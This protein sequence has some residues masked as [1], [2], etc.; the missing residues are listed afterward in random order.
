MEINK[1]GNPS[2]GSVSQIGRDKVG[3]NARSIS[4]ILANNPEKLDFCV[5]KTVK[6]LK[7]IHR[8]QVPKGK[9]PDMKES[10]L[11][12]AAYLRNLLPEHLQRL[13]LLLPFPLSPYRLPPCLPPA[14]P[15][16]TRRSPI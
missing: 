10:A 13:L 7:R 11:S 9:L 4:V 8:E 16:S 14:R 12:Q 2:S 5:E 6:L 1:Q 3:S 15:P